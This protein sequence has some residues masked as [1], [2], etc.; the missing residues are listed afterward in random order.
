MDIETRIKLIAREPIE[1]VVTL[2]DLRK[3]LETKAKITAYDGFET[4]GLMHIGSGILR[5]IKINDL[6]EA[7]INF[8]LLI[9][10]WYAWINNKMGGDLELIKKT[11]EYFIEGW[12]ACGIDMKKVKVL[13]ASD[14]VKDSK[15]WKNVIKI[16]KIT[17]IQRAIRAGTIMGREEGEMQYVAQ[18][19]YPMMQAY[20]PFYLGADIMQLGMDQ[21]KAMI[22]TREVAPKI[23]RSIRV[24]VMH[25]LLIGLQG[26]QRMGPAESKMSKSIAE[27]AIF[28]HDKKEQIANK[29]NNAFCPPKIIEGNPILEI[30]RYIIFRKF[31]TISIKRQNKTNLEVQSYNELE[32]AYRQGEIHPADLKIKTIEIL[33]EIL[34]PVRS[35]FEKNKK[36]KELYELVKSSQI[37][38]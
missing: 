19:L 30:W 33:D 34:E 38:R 3:L 13:W 14:L 1:E 8:I 37:T 10:D 26:N 36:A 22:L 24:A 23:D 18:V 27:S 2:E 31:K 17:T 32:K 29:I 5:S 9:A 15:Y 6:F 4:S 20:D 21:R 28:I 25:H 35:Y 11:G 16:S 12:K 7:N